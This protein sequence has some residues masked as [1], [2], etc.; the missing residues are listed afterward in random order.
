MRWPGCDYHSHVLKIMALPAEFDDRKRHIM[1][2]CAFEAGIIDNL[3]SEGLLFTT[4]RK[5][6]C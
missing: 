1:R 6:I 3:N 4:E 2:T 5:K